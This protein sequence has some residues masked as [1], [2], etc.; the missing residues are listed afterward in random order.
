MVIMFSNHIK[1]LLVNSKVFPFISLTLTPLIMLHVFTVDVNLAQVVTILLKRLFKIITYDFFDMKSRMKGIK[2]ERPSL[3]L[4]GYSF[5]SLID[6]MGIIYW[7][8]IVFMVSLLFEPG[9]F[10]FKSKV[11]KLD[12][13]S[14]LLKCI[15]TGKNLSK[16]LYNHLAV[17]QIIL[18]TSLI[19]SLQNGDFDSFFSQ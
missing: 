7:F 18:V 11:A 1:D 4:A 19:I 13:S 16:S 6:N 2:L 3:S 15:Q 5:V 10:I 17:N 9:L 8:F 12:K 14:K